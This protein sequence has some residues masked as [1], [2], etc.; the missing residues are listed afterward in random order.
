MSR[1]T[2]ED[3]RRYDALVERLVAG[4]FVSP[5]EIDATLKRA[6]MSHDELQED[7]Q[8]LKETLN[9]NNSIF[10]R[11]KARQVDAQARY[12][13]LVTRLA[14]GE[15]VDDKEAGDIL[16]LAHRTPE[17]LER[18]LQRER[19]I[20]ELQEIVA[21]EPALVDQERELL[22]QQAEKFQQVA[23]RRQELEKD[24]A[25]L[26]HVASLLLK[27]RDAKGRIGEARGEIQRLTRPPE[28]KQPEP[29]WRPGF[30]FPVPPGGESIPAE[31]DWGALIPPMEVKKDTN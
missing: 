29:S 9:M 20:R 10:D 11:L 2:E 25:E 17:D 7:V 30:A 19:R 14:A 24:E 13:S 22:S 5:V 26:T 18:D 12:K 16:D 8:T 4:R 28:R 21:G 15:E 6:S 3:R 31:S 23:K 1:A 27:V